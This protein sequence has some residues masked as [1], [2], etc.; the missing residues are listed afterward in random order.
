[1]FQLH[2]R[3]E[4]D[5]VLIGEFALCLALLSKDANYPWV[6]LV[7]RRS[8]IKEIH[9][10]S[11]EDRRQLLHESCVVAEAM[12]ATFTPDKLNIA[13]I[14]NMIPQLHLHHVVRFE[15]DVAWP[16]PVWGAVA[17]LAYEDQM[18]ANRVAV[19]RQSLSGFLR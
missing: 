13:S 3:L 19:M 1:M 6:I 12:E 7:P 17:A 10:L 14:G 16:G 15:S 2:Q 4:A 5:T 8:E 11:L 9:Q 18:L